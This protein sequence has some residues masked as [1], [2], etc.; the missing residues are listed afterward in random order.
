MVTVVFQKDEYVGHVQGHAEWEEV[1]LKARDTQEAIQTI[2]VEGGKGL[3]TEVAMGWE[4]KEKG[5]MKRIMGDC[6]YKTF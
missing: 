4:N 3:A 5:H 2:P 6:N 1:R